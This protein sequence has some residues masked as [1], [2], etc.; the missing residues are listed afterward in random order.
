MVFGSKYLKSHNLSIFK[1][2]KSILEIFV[3]P[4]FEYTLMGN[5]KDYQGLFIRAVKVEFIK[6]SKISL[7]L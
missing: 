6:K 1:V 3:N 7:N 2:I 5:M 4:K